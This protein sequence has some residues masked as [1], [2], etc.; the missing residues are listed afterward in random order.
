M[1]FVYSLDNKIQN[2]QLKLDVTYNSKIDTNTKYIN[3]GVKKMLGKLCRFIRYRTQFSICYS[4]LSIHWVK[5]LNCI[6]RMKQE[7]GQL[8]LSQTFGYRIEANGRRDSRMEGFVFICNAWKP[9]VENNRFE[10]PQVKT[11][12][13][14][15][16]PATSNESWR[17][18]T[19]L[20][21]RKFSPGHLVGYRLLATMS[22][23]GSIKLSSESMCADEKENS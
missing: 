18:L 15:A 4:V 14:H 11:I 12:L 2:C 1:N 17:E 7:V 16:D 5:Y 10:Y 23:K 21:V 19:W 3:V 9:C 20:K 6:V 13:V 8:E 22:S